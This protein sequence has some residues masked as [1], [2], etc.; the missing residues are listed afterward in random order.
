M[1]ESSTLRNN[2][3]CVSCFFASGGMVGRSLNRV[4]RYVFENRV[5][6]CHYSIFFIRI[7]P[8]QK[9]LIIYFFS[10][11]FTLKK[12]YKFLFFLFPLIST[13]FSFCPSLPCFPPLFLIVPP[14]FF[15]FISLP[16][17]AW[18]IMSIMSV[19]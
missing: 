19:G 3:V 17:C 18:Y 4:G 10:N 16:P 5:G 6:Q 7:F 13:L 8:A 12:L 1:N 2:F 11:C 14:Y 9:T 15:C